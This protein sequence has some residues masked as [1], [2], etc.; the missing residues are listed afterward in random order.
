MLHQGT[1]E[2]LSAAAACYPRKPYRPSDDL[3][4]FILVMQKMAAR[5][6]PCGVDIAPSELL[7]LFKPYTNCFLISGFYC[8]I[9]TRMAITARGG[10]PFDLDQAK[11]SPAFVSLLEALRG[12]LMTSYKDLGR[13]ALEAKY[14]PS[15]KDIKI[16]ASNPD[17]PIPE[18][19]AITHSRVLGLFNDA[20]DN[21]VW[22]EKEN[23]PVDRLPPHQNGNPHHPWR[24]SVSRYRELVQS[25]SAGVTNKRT[26]AGA[27]SADATEF[28]RPRLDQPSGSKSRGS[29]GG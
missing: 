16:D 29:R 17:E 9:N 26:A 25:Q 19:A 28:K 24:D 20:L 7:D 13:G 22:L 3:E 11:N 8:A 6:H 2:Y 5:F 1:W 12:L 14:G 10:A 15:A 23:T 21:G 27:A 18:L 4:S